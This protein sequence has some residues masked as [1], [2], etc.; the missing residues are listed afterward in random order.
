MSYK[1]GK[2]ARDR[3]RQIEDPSERN[4]A[5]ECL[6]GQVATIRTQYSRIQST[7]TGSFDIDP[8][9]NLFIGPDYYAIEPL[10]SISDYVQQRGCHLGGPLGHA[11]QALNHWQFP[12]IELNDESFYWMHQDLHHDNVLVDDNYHITAVIGNSS[13]E[14]LPLAFVFSALPMFEMDF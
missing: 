9:G 13:V 7:T 8:S 11:L 14:F 6:V 1:R 3:L 5:L 2:T 12:G 10:T 4:Q